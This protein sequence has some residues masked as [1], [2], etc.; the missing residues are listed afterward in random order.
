MRTIL[1]SGLLGESAGLA[2]S[3][4]RLNHFP[5]SECTRSSADFSSASI[6]ASSLW[7][8]FLRSD[9]S[10]SGILQKRPRNKG[11][12]KVD[13]VKKIEKTGVIAIGTIYIRLCRCG[14]IVGTAERNISNSTGSVFRRRASIPTS[15]SGLGAE[16]QLSLKCPGQK[17]FSPF[18][19]RSSSILIIS[20]TS[21]PTRYRIR[22]ANM[23]TVQIFFSPGSAYTS[24]FNSF[25]MLA[26]ICIKLTNNCRILLATPSLSCGRFFLLVTF[27]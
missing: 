3:E 14:K 9:S 25:E 23:R 11:R 12:L 8:Y 24:S 18:R 27:K 20:Y 1:N 5:V 7:M 17:C 10:R 16:T 22:P 4:D 13:C 26:R 15:H 21:R 19:Y 2:V 6:R